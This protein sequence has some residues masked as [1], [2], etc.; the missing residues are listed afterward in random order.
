MQR[1]FLSLAYDGSKY[2]GWQI[3]P[4]ATTVQEV[5]N[6]ALSK[7]TGNNM[8]T[9]GAGRTDTGVHARFFV[10]H[11]EVDELKFPTDQFIY[12][13]NSILPFD[14]SC[15]NLV[16]VEEDMHARFNALSRS[17]TYHI[18]Q[19]KDPFKQEYS[20]FFPFDL[21]INLMNEAC[22]IILNHTD[23]TSFSK[24]HTDVKTNNCNVMHAK[25]IKSGHSILFEIKADRFLRNMVRALVGTLIEV[26][27]KKKSLEQFK[28]I[29]DA[30]DRS[31]AGTSAPAKGLFL[32][33]IFYNEV[34][35]KTLR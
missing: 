12:K 14:I 19:K 20:Y 23:F 27:Q 28:A 13:L 9:I 11:F 24:L 25:W 21:D 7:I 26:G 22:K 30:K 8:D 16:E 31:N 15:F 33:D 35:A 6:D 32:D 29:L 5:L 1:Y 4:N 18:H 34:L 3:Q 10:V 17:Y 2:H